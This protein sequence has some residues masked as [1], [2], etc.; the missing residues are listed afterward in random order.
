MRR[1]PSVLNEGQERR[2]LLRLRRA[3]AAARPNGGSLAVSIGTSGAEDSRQPGEAPDAPVA[4]WRVGGGSY[5][6]CG[7]KGRGV[8]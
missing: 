5:V 3:A 7:W 4:G 8:L 2:P 6:C 1:P